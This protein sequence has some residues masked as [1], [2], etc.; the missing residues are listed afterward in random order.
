M[1][2]TMYGPGGGLS[3][4]LN[5]WANLYLIANVSYVYMKGEAKLT[6]SNLDLVTRG[7]NSSMAFAWYIAPA[8]TTLYIGGRYQR[9][10]EE[11]KDDDNF[12]YHEMPGVT[13]SAV[14]SFSI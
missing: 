1:Y 13:A 5:I 14:Y 6:D 10:Y 12:K 7:V 11:R 4:T 2:R 8:S 9:L 3:A